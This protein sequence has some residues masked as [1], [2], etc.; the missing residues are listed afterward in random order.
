[1][2]RVTCTCCQGTGT[3]E[4]NGEYLLTYELL[5]KSG[6]TWAAKLAPELQCNATAAN[7]RL[8]ALEAKGL[9]TTASSRRVRIG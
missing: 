8:A 2:I 6:E 1:M 9:A 4:L 7:N 5:K 3:V